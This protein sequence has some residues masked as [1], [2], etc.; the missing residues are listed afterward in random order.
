MTG[1][2]AELERFRLEVLAHL[3][4]QQQLRETDDRQRFVE[5]LVSLGSA[6]GYRF[7]AIEVEEALR[8]SWRSWIERWID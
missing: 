2:P 1:N 6:H 4:L 3:D 5:L 8:A 7:T